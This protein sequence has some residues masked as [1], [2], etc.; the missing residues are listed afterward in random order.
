MFKFN[1][2]KRIKGLATRKDATP[3]TSATSKEPAVHKYPSMIRRLFTKR[4]KSNLLS[5]P[6]ATPTVIIVIPAPTPVLP[7]PDIATS[8]SPGIDLSYHTSPTLLPSVVMPNTA[9]A[10]VFKAPSAPATAATCLTVDKSKTLYDDKA[11]YVR[12]LIGAKKEMDSYRARAERAESELERVKTELDALRLQATGREILD[13]ERARIRALRRNVE[14]ERELLRHE[15]VVLEKCNRAIERKKKALVRGRTY[16]EQTRALLAREKTVVERAR[17]AL[18]HEKASTERA[19]A[20]LVREKTV[21]SKTKKSLVEEMAST[22]REKAL[23][24]LEKTVIEEAKKSLAEEKASTERVRSL[25]HR[26]R[27]VVEKTRK[28]LVQE[29][30]DLGAVQAALTESAEEL[31]KLYH[32][33]LEPFEESKG[34]FREVGWQVRNCK[35][36]T[37]CPMYGDEGSEE[38]PAFDLMAEK[39]EKLLARREIRRRRAIS[40]DDRLT[41]LPMFKSRS[42]RTKEKYTRIASQ[43]S[44]SSGHSTLTDTG[45]VVSAATSTDCDTPPASPTAGCFKISKQNA[46]T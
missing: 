18:V 25:I 46:W 1:I 16:V 14:G 38:D 34:V 9:V 15:R 6:V 31:E 30:R 43:T 23:L 32:D 19:R 4:S 42:H 35:A 37:R 22:E 39:R 20:L 28:A 36:L 11:H 33:C 41:P 44:V 29:R 26:E 10:E 21:I 2:V 24:V 17:K 5:L 7:N 8:G 45:S 3:V 12:T 27:L 40:G 13:K